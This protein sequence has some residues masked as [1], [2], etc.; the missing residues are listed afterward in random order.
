MRFITEKISVS[1]ALLIYVMLLITTFFI[2]NNIIDYTYFPFFLILIFYTGVW[3]IVL[4]SIYKNSGEELFVY[5][6]YYVL[7]MPG[8]IYLIS[9]NIDIKLWNIESL[10][11]IHL[12]LL[13]LLIVLRIVLYKTRHINMV[14]VAVVYLL[15]LGNFIILNQLFTSWYIWNFLSHG[16]K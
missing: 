14:R 12:F 9:F 8:I 7:G 2:P 6:L 5:D 13:G 11:N 10:Q 3:Y 16:Y 4:K 15:P 1:K